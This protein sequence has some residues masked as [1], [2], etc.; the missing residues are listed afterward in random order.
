V[1]C[2]IVNVREQI[3]HDIQTENADQAIDVSLDVTAN[4]QAVEKSH[5]RNPVT[6]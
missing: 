4:Q 6:I 2:E 5:E 1:L 3:D